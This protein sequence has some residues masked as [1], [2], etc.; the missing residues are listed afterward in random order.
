VRSTAIVSHQTL[1]WPD[2]WLKQAKGMKFGFFLC[3]AD[4]RRYYRHRAA[5]ETGRVGILVNL[6]NGVHGTRVGL[7]PYH[8]SPTAPQ[9]K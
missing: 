4:S 1:I 3:L 9:K 8:I 2:V 5:T 7:Q 6:L